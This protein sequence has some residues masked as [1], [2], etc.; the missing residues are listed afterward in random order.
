MFELSI[1]ER[2]VVNSEGRGRMFFS[3]SGKG[4]CSSCCQ[5][6]NMA[7]PR[8]IGSTHSSKT[9]GLDNQTGCFV[10]SG[11]PDSIYQAL[12]EHDQL[13]LQKGIIIGS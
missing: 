2:E 9:V 7:V 6:F 12:W 13:N 5:E 1:A 4:P 3:R 8:C 11:E 10:A